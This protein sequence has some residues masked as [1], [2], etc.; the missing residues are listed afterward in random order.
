[1]WLAAAGAEAQPRCEVPSAGAAVDV[2]VTPPGS[3]AFPL[4][5]R[6]NFVVRPRADDHIVRLHL[7]ALLVAFP[8]TCS[9]GNGLGKASENNGR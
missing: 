8:Q 4:L 5:V 2:T 9:L 1:M 7:F 3:P 6:D